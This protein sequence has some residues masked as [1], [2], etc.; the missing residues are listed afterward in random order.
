MSERVAY[1]EGYEACLDGCRM[2]ECP[3][4]YQAGLRYAWEAGWMAALSKRAW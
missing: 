4:K 3:S 1:A 2:S